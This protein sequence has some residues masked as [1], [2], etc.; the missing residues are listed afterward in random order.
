MATKQTQEV[1]WLKRMANILKGLICGI[2]GHRPLS[3][4]SL[5]G[6]SLIRIYD[7][8]D[9]EVLKVQ[10]CRTCDAL[11]W[12]PGEDIPPA[13]GRDVSGFELICLLQANQL[14]AMGPKRN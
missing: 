9:R 6:D 7:E 1:G 8:A 2:R 13:Y 12:M 4:S 3:L 10:L 14:R 11:F 5:T